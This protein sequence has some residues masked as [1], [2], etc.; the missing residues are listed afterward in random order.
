MLRAALPRALLSARSPS[1]SVASMTTSAPYIHPLTDIVLQR[2]KSNHSDFL[3]QKFPQGPS[4]S[5]TGTLLLT[6]PGVAISTL[7]DS[8]ANSH[9]L[10]LD[11]KEKN[12]GKARKGLF[13]MMD[14]NAP[15]WH[16]SKLS[17]EEKIW[18]AVDGMVE[19][20]HANEVNS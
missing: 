18:Q 6:A 11:L 12:T 10:A 13:V 1:F 4:I 17:V 14:N 9:L 3:A 19:E 2:L 7:Y 8:P 20:I 16:T 15:A 5:E